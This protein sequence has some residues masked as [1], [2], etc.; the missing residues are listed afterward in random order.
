MTSGGHQFGVI[1]A[2]ICEDGVAIFG[3][4]AWYADQHS[5]PVVAP[6]MRENH[7]TLTSP[8]HHVTLSIG[9]KISALKKFACLARLEFQEGGIRRR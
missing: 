7:K 1:G 3:R 2:I 5:I 9:H 4:S 6:R 8:T